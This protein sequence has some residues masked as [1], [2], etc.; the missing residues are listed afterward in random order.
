MLILQSVWLDRNLCSAIS[1][2]SECCEDLGVDYTNIKMNST[3]ISI[4]PQVFTV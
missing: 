1:A 3:Q 4:W 2:E